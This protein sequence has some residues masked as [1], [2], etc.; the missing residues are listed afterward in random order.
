MSGRFGGRHALPRIP[1]DAKGRRINI[2]IDFGTSTTKVCARAALGYGTDV[3][4]FALSLNGSGS[5]EHVFLCPSVV[6][7]ADSKLYFGV[8]AERRRASGA[9][10]FDHLKVCVGCQAEK[11]GRSLPGC[12]SVNPAKRAC[13]GIFRFS[14]GEKHYG[15][16]ARELATFH[17]AWAMKQSRSSLPY[18]LT[19][20]EPADFTYNVGVPLDQLHEASRLRDAYRKMTF[21]AWC[22]ADGMDQGLALESGLAW[23][24]QLRPR[25]LPDLAQS[26]VQLCPELGAA[27][28]AF[29]ASPRMR[30]GMHGLVDIGAWT[31]EVSF[32]N[33]TRS[34]GQPTVS[35]YS[36]ATFRVG[37]TDIDERTLR[38]LYEL[39]N[40]PLPLGPDPGVRTSVREI[41]QQRE[42]GTFATMT[43]SVDKRFGRRPTLSTLQFPRDCV[44]ERIRDGFRQAILLAGEKDRR[45]SSW[46]GLPIYVS[47][48]GRRE[49]ALWERLAEA[50]TIA[51]GA[52][53]LP[54]N[55]DV[56]GLPPAL[57]D[58]FVIAAGL[59]LPLPLWHDAH[60]PQ[61]VEPYRAP[62]AR[63]RQDSEDLGYLEP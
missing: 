22:I 6:A 43:L 53:P 26:K 55:D 5:G 37:G 7:I 17:L 16:L 50:F 38:A 4:T 48:G 61:E 27:L 11:T 59:A 62:R 40:L 44:G 25:E 51:S 12:H 49:S 24:E 8:E 21:D 36:G 31:T 34:S 2:G 1:A 60:L 57:L 35:F 41:R 58:R 45:Q 10:V 42:I 39:W 46:E 18:E 28:V 32:F 30:P 54:P 19:G 29:V 14:R 47:G 15:V 3:P 33:L 56:H 52:V 63:P 9:T 13:D 23:L 20:P